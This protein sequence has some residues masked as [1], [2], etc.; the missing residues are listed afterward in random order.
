[1]KG[2]YLFC[3]LL[4]VLPAVPAYADAAGAGSYRGPI[5]VVAAADGRSLFVANA[6]AEQIA[7][8]DAGSGEQVRVVALPGQPHGLVLSPDGATLYVTCGGLRGTVQLVDVP[9]GQ[10]RGGIPVGHTP[11]GLCIS[12]DGKRLYVCNRFNN[13]VSVVDTVARRELG[14]VS[15]TREPV[16]AAITPDGNTVFVANLLPADASVGAT[17]SAVITAIDADTQKTKTLRL[18]NG[19][20]GARGLSVSPDG[21]YVYVTH[22]LSRYHL[23]TT[24]VERGWINTN[25]LSIIDASASVCL[26][27]VLLDEVDRGAANPWGIATSADGRLICVAHAGTNELSV[28]DAPALLAK[29]TARTAASAPSPVY[30]GWSGASSR[31][32]VCDDLTFLNGPRRRMALPGIGPRGV[33]ISGK[34]AYVCEYFSDTL[35]AVKLNPKPV[36]AARQIS[37]GPPPVMTVQRRGEMLFNSADLCLQ[38]WQS[39]ASCHPDARVDGLN[40]D[41]INDGLGNPK[42]TRSMLLAHQTPPAMAS[43]VR[44]GAKEAVRAGIR[45][46]QFAVRPEPDADAIDAYLQALE[47]VPSPSLRNGPSDAVRRGEKLFFDE[48]IGCG[49]CHPVPKYT[50]LRPY[51]VLSRGAYDRAGAFDTP[52][53]I[54]CWRT[55]PYMHDGRYPTLRSLIEEG[56]HGATHGAVNDLTPEQIND[57]V[58]FMLSL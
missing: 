36:T 41:L 55:A 7:V 2:Q 1:M 18:P 48:K 33:T 17:V 42:N 15:V 21:K 22:I 20:S 13:D 12:R 50:D 28:I 11:T 40:W 51:D 37:L 8:V 10:I 57:L 46:I 35:A 23:P 30:D 4:T 56:R 32:A 45:H 14:R 5:A 44:P 49:I 54:E 58:E 6:D 39:C 24:Q 9:G 25:A 47:P 38:R 31:V 3:V 53:I 34:Q 26:A 29:L 27:T 16:A 52:T 19:S 43:G